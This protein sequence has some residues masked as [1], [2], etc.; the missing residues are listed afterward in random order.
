MT[1]QPGKTYDYTSPECDRRSGERRLI[2]YD[3]R[4]AEN[5]GVTGAVGQDAHTA[6]INNPEN[7]NLRIYK[8]RTRRTTPDRRVK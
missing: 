3:R 5:P 2:A 8:V 1:I 4:M 7:E 6:W